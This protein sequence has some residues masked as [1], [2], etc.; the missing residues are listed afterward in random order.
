MTAVKLLGVKCEE[1]LAIGD[2]YD[3]DVA[4]PLE[5]GMGGILVCGVSEVYQLHQSVL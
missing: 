4:L 1:C 3:M 2:R 5:L